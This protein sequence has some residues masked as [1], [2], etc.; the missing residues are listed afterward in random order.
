MVLTAAAGTWGPVSPTLAYQWKRDGAT[1]EGATARTYELT[2]LDV[3][4]SIT[5]EVSATAPGFTSALVTSV[6]TGDIALGVLSPAPAP[7]ITGTMGTGSTATATPGTWGPGS[8]SFAYRWKR[9]GT[10]IADATS[11]TYVIAAADLGASITVEVT[12]TRNGYSTVVKTS[13]ARTAIS[14]TFTNSVLPSITGTAAVGSV[15]TASQGT[16]SPM[17]DSA[18]YQWLRNNVAIRGATNATFSL[19]TADRGKRISVRVTVVKTS[20]TTTSKT[21]A[22]VKVS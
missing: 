11:A 5:V 7:T 19:T 14:G 6:A 18:T 15:L 3:G 13:A 12:A 10:N 8:V 2:A 22:I 21:S 17:F 20:Y 9:N 1:I 16:W 4:T